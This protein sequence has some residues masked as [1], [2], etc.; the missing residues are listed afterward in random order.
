MTDKSVSLTKGDWVVHTYYGVGQIKGIEKKQI[1][2]EQTKYFKVQARNSTYFIPV[3][4]AL[5]DRVRRVASNYKLNKA[6]NILK[7]TPEELDSDHNKRK[8]QIAELAGDGALEVTAQLVRDLYARRY[9]NG[10][11]DHEENLLTKMTSR[12]V[13][14]WA[15]SKDTDIE[16]VQERFNA[17]IAEQFPI[18]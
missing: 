15:I 18:E 7:D 5:N 11:N 12:L 4:N 16:D 6:I 8:R 10:L 13:Y 17:I 2:E 1:G 14:E 9:S 3:D